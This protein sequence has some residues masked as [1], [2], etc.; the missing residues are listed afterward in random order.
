VADKFYPEHPTHPLGKFRRQ[1][2]ARLL[3]K[4]VRRDLEKTEGLYFYSVQDK[5]KLLTNFEDRHKVTMRLWSL[6]NG[7]TTSTG[8]LI[9]DTFATN[10]QLLTNQ[11][12]V[13]VKARIETIRDIAQLVTGDIEKN[14]LAE[15]ALLE[16]ESG[17]AKENESTT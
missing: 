8:A 14:L 9:D 7:F 10:P 13:T 3:I 1:H 2:L 16:L 6:T 17:K 12:W 5:F 4:R 15:K 11:F